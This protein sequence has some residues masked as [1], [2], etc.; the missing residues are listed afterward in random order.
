MYGCTVCL[1][2]CV[3]P[4]PSPPA[5]VCMPALAPAQVGVVVSLAPA[6]HESMVAP[7][8]VETYGLWDSVAVAANGSAALPGR[9]FALV[10]FDGDVERVSMLD[11]NA[12]SPVNSEVRADGLYS[13][14]THADAR[15]RTHMTALACTHEARRHS[16]FSARWGPHPHTCPRVLAGDC[17]LP[18][19]PPPPTLPFRLKAL[20]TP[21][22]HPP[23]PTRTHLP[24]LSVGPLL[25]PPRAKRTSCPSYSGKTAMAPR[26]GMTAC[27]RTS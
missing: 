2:V 13:R 8:A 18:R 25:P 9:G 16:H 24:F 14:T 23:T 10:S 26:D 27:C 4:R 15:R 5:I 12:V 19:S 20:V 6:L 1:P 22:P 21:P 11:L 3:C 17:L 7:S